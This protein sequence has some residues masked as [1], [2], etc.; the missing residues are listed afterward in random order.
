[1]TYF[2]RQQLDD[3]LRNWLPD[4]RILPLAGIVEDAW[5]R[6]ARHGDFERWQRALQSM[7]DVRNAIYDTDRD[8]LRIGRPGDLD[9]EQRATLLAALGE[10]HP[11]R[12][13]PF[14]F[15]G[16]H[17]DTEWRSDWKW[18]R[19]QHDI[20]PLHGRRVLDVGCGS[21]Y[22]CWRMRG[23]GAELVIG[24]DPTILFA[25]Q[26]QAVQRYIR[27]AQVQ[28]WPV[29]I[30]EM[31]RLPFDSVFSMGILYHRRSPLDHL[32]QLRS[33]L[34]DGGELILET[35]VVEGDERACLLPP[36]RYA[37]MRNVWFIPS[38]DMLRVWLGRCGF[39]DIRLIH[40]GPT[41]VREQRSTSW[42]RFE[43]LADY[44]DADDPSRTVEGHP[45][46]LRAI[47]AATRQ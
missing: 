36:G 38:V 15:F 8:C 44:L 14:E 26:F 11:W 22:H 12:K 29:S 43:S 17:I 25:M 19:L 31:P 20:A 21:G 16:I 27:D 37:K 30:D 1:M 40:C 5:R 9:E 47:L 7:P 33:L 10:L 46:P 42:M 3:M 39:G 13:G 18:R 32:L 24:I 41:S 34:R 45:A 23:A 35:L 6:A 4:E 28:H 2:D